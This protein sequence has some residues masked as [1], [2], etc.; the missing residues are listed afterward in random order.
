[1]DLDPLARA[2][3]RGRQLDDTQRAA[4][5]H[6][7]GPL[8]VLGGPGTGKTTVLVERFVRLATCEVPPHRVLLV[9][10]DRE[11]SQRLRDTLPWRLS[12]RALVEIHVHT[13]P[14]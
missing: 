8:L 2:S 12:G 4:V 13:W 10:R 1:M 3:D 6:G 14:A 11:T 5:E 9:A 7:G